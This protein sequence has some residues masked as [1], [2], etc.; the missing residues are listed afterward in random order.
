MR[1]ANAAGRPLERF[2]RVEAASG[3]LLL[4]AA[5]VALACASSP[6]ADAYAA[7][8]H[9]ELGIRVG[10]FQFVRSLE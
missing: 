6:W 10:D 3:I 8:W 4:I 9:T 1:L 7:F 5:A 2:L